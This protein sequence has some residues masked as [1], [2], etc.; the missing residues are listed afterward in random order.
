MMILQQ[1]CFFP[2]A[3]TSPLFLDF[4]YKFNLSY[5][6]L[7]SCY[8]KSKPESVIH[9]NKNNIYWHTSHFSA[10]FLWFVQ[11]LSAI[12]KHYQYTLCWSVRNKKCRLHQHLLNMPNETDNRQAIKATVASSVNLL[13]HK[14]PPECIKQQRASTDLR[15]SLQWGLLSDCIIRNIP[16]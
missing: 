12:S 14:I 7:C 2:R 1:S 6:L 16:C 4:L 10:H 9:Q 8:C 5:R 11:T 3:L 13:F 15:L